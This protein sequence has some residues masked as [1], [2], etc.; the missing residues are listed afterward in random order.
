MQFVWC[1]SRIRLTFFSFL[2]SD[3]DMFLG[4]VNMLINDSIYLLDESLS[5]LAKI[6]QLLTEMDSADYNERFNT[7]RPP[8]SHLVVPL[9]TFHDSRTSVKK[10]WMN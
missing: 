3:D 5:K 10:S 7:V 2:I 6:K 4:F 9:L 8:P 1:P